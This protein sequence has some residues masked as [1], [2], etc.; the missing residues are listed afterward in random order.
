MSAIERDIAA[1]TGLQCF[2]YI[3]ICIGKKGVSHLNLIYLTVGVSPFLFWFVVSEDGEGIQLS[4]CDGKAQ[5]GLQR[6][7]HRSCTVSAVIS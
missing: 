7:D 5:S 4:L 6:D 2:G 3:G 1:A